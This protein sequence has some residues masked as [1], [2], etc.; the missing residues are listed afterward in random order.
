MREQATDV[1]IREKP[2]EIW[3][4]RAVERPCIRL[5]RRTRTANLKLNLAIYKQKQNHHEIYM[6]EWTPNK[7]K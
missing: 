2:C 1:G 5:G 6:Q 3:M 4:K 7:R